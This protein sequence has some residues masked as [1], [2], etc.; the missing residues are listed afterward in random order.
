MR[1]RGVMGNT[2][3]VERVVHVE[4]KEKMKEFEEKLER[5]KEEIRLKAA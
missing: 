5:E 3:I 1:K 4:D 2:N